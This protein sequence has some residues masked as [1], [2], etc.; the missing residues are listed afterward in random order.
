M[1]TS[2]MEYQ[3][4]TVRTACRV[5]IL[6][7]TLC[8][9]RFLN[10][11]AEPA[12][13]LDRQDAGPEPFRSFLS[14]ENKNSQLG[15]WD[16]GGEKAKDTL[17]KAS[18]K[19]N[20][21]N[22]RQ[23]SKEKTFV[24]KVIPGEKKPLNNENELLEAKKAKVKTRATNSVKPARELEK[25]SA[26]D[27]LR[28][29]AINEKHKTAIEQPDRKKEGP[30]SIRVNPRRNRLEDIPSS[31]ELQDMVRKNRMDDSLKTAALKQ[32][33]L[34]RLKQEMLKR[35]KLE[36]EKRQEIAKARA[37]ARLRHEEK[38][39][40]GQSAELKI[41]LGKY[42]MLDT[43]KPVQTKVK[44]K[45]PVI[46]GKESVVKA[47]AEE[48]A[49]PVKPA[50][51]QP[52]SLRVAM[53]KT[54][55][56]KQEPE[57]VVKAVKVPVEERQKQG[58]GP[59]SLRITIKRDVVQDSLKP[60][61]SMTQ[62]KALERQRRL[63]IARSKAEAKIVHEEKFRSRQPS[64]L[65]MMLGIYAAQDTLK[66]VP[67]KMKKKK[68]DAEISVSVVKAPAEEKAQPVKPAMKQP[69][70]LRVTL[71]KA[72]IRDSLKAA[73]HKPEIKKQEPESVVKVVKVPVE[74]RQKQGGWPDSLRITIKKDVVQDSLKPVLS[75]SERKA[76]ERQRRLQIARSKA[77]AKIVHEEKF[78][79]RQP[80]GF[81]MML[82]I[83]AAQDTLK[84]VQTKVK[85]KPPVIEGKESVVKAPA[86]EKA[87]PIKPAM[88]QPDSLRVTLKKAAIRDSLK[89][90]VQKPEIK[91]Q[92]PES[93]VKAV[94]VPVEERQKQGARPDSLIISQKREEKQDRMKQL[95]KRTANVSDS[96][97]AVVKEVIPAEKPVVINRD[98]VMLDSLVAA[99]NTS[100]MRGMYDNN[101]LTSA[102]QV[103]VLSRKVYGM[104][105]SSEAAALKMLADVYLSRKQFAMAEPLYKQALDIRES[106]SGKDRSGFG[107]LLTSLGV[108]AA[109]QENYA[110]AERYYKQA[111]DVPENAGGLNSFGMATTLSNMGRMYLKQRN[112]NLATLFYN[113]AV[114]LRE[115][116]G[117]PPDPG[118]ASILNNVAELYSESK[119]F[120][121]ALQLYQKAL[122]I[123][124]K[125]EGPMH[126][127][128]A[129]SISGI[130]SIY[131]RQGQYTGAELLF[132]KALTIQEQAY[133]SFH[134][135][136]AK[137][138]Q[139]IA[140]VCRLQQK[141][142]AA[143]QYMKR[144]IDMTMKIFPP[145]HLNVAK[146]LNSMALIYDSRGQYAAAEAYY[147]RALVIC[148]SN[149]GKGH[150][151][152]AQILDNMAQMYLKMGRQ[153][154][155]ESLAN[156]AR[157]IRDEVDSR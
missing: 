68:P 27:S 36:Q 7:F 14:N 49:Q 29:A 120:D 140:S 96:T 66:P 81:K 122:A 131:L 82:G 97:R 50:L 141:Y 145:N 142:D 79:S 26:S 13:V 133:G 154:Q 22:V 30:D 95:P 76:L 9:T 100:Y 64:G 106:H 44:K 87:Q 77:E 107:L 130:A 18:K 138:L 74:E 134:S 121:A 31:S 137:T 33:R 153:K 143:Q 45:P 10:L 32:Q 62:R 53:Q 34:E 128:V 23:K 157:S 25:E 43:L 58:A 52:D 99:A 78:R 3:K 102:K 129:S 124:E 113:Q 132:Q 119:Q 12:N 8:L 126:P 89:A 92:E 80:S 118:M 152:Y 37:E 57:R 15:L 117:A 91:K 54:E 112:M 151:D 146:S 28:H 123:F 41:T 135:E 48:K 40:S 51:K 147:R 24:R 56:K 144:S 84:P 46:E 104:R 19:G 6:S 108:V 148:E 98:K 114:A 1:I 109:E 116:T 72:A 110:V 105:S 93:V 59:D 139:N 101:T 90:A 42:D 125:T 83:Y 63:Q 5:L 75:L 60:V 35:K 73:V 86:E 155:A 39:R 47:P 67:P 150:Y 88:K 2:A 70:S 61:L 71:K 103:L 20:P 4:K 136:V 65:K 69:D 111:L 149:R 85:K 156:K 94:K 115:K 38:I 55:I 21:G 11:G 16:F 17:N 127:D